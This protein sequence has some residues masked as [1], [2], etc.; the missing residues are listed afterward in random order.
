MRLS[1][2]ERA[3][4]YRRLA[5]VEADPAKAELLHQIAIEAESGVL[6]TS[7]WAT[8][9]THVGNPSHRNILNDQPS[10]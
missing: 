6:V 3:V 8:P 7:D 5:L 9:A 2:H 4:K 10:F 1:P